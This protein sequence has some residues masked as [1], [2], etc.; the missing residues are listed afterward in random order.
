MEVLWLVVQ[1]GVAD[2]WSESMG[3]RLLRRRA[4]WMSAARCVKGAST[5][6]RLFSRRIRRGHRLSRTRLGRLTC[7]G[8]CSSRV[9]WYAIVQI[10]RGVKVVVEEGVRGIEIMHWEILG[11]CKR[12]VGAD[13]DRMKEV[14]NRQQSAGSPGRADE[15]NII[16]R[17]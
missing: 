13:R 15:Q 5:R 12:G 17:V 8:V 2:G 11:S 14:K 3:W 1:R 9:R 4:T 6:G 10:A 16:T 7:R